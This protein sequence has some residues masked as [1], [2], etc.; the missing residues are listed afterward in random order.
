MKLRYPKSNVF[1]DEN[2]KYILALSVSIPVLLDMFI[3]KWFA[4]S[5]TSGE[6]YTPKGF[7]KILKQ[8]SEPYVHT[9]YSRERS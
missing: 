5:R 4:K 1:G 7:L 9:L 3:I 6:H 2:L 8:H